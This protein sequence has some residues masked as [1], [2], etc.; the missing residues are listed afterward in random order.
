MEKK[1]FLKTVSFEPSQNKKKR[2]VRLCDLSSLETEI[3]SNFNWHAH[4]L[5]H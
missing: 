1:I 4:Y 2:L 3:G 5:H